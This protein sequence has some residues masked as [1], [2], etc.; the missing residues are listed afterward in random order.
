MILT[1]LAGLLLHRYSGLRAERLI[2]R[3][4]FKDRT[5]PKNSVFVPAIVAALI[6]SAL[7][8]IGLSF[9]QTSPLVKNL[10]NSQIPQADVTRL[11]D[12]W[13]TQ[14]QT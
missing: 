3:V 8:L 5:T 12:L 2:E 6:L 13:P 10:F 7:C 1:T 9:S 14:L 11:F 4:V